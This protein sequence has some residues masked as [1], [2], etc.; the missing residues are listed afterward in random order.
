MG[1]PRSA[2]CDPWAT[3]ADLCSPCDDYSVD[4]A[5]MDD[6]LQ[7]ASDVLYALSGRQF[8]GVCTTEVHLDKRPIHAVSGVDPAVRTRTYWPSGDRSRVSVGLYPLID[9]TEVVIDGAT[10]DASVYRID[11]FRWLTRVDEQGWQWSDT[12]KVT[13]THGRT[14]PE[15]GVRAAAALGCQLYLSCQPE[16]TGDCVLPQRVTN[17]TRQGMSMVVLDPFEFLNDGKTGVYEVDLFL[18]SYNP[19][20]LRRRAAVLSPDIGSRIHRRGT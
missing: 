19:S 15:M 8:P 5:L 12:F 16:T 4:A 2:T 6:A 14:P 3:A 7:A 18:K 13:A 10:V 1:E 17:I 9:I 11:D 20:G